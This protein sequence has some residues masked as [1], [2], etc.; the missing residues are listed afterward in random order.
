MFGSETGYG[1]AKGTDLYERSCRYV[2]YMGVNMQPKQDVPYY[3][4]YTPY[5]DPTS[6]GTDLYLAARFDIEYEAE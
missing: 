1:S 5:A 4:D 3:V 2:D 6:Y